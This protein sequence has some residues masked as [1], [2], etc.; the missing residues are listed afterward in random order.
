[1][2]FELRIEDDFSSA[3]SLRG[4]QGRCEELH[5]HN[6]KVEIGVVGNKLDKTGLA[7]DFKVLKKRLR[8]ILDTLDHKHL[9]KIAYFKRHNPSSENIARYIYERLLAVLKRDKVILKHV[10]VW[11]SENASAIYT[12]DH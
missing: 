9:N 5:G 12:V 10:R 3:H 6:W 2:A 1:M 8:R 4:Y 7:I 11:E